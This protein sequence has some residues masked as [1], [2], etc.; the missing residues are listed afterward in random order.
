M[1]TGLKNGNDTAAL[2]LVQL[3]PRKAINHTLQLVFAAAGVA[4]KLPGLQVEEGLSVNVRG[5]NG[6]SAGNKGNI[7]IALYP[8]ALTNGG[9]RV[10]TPDTEIP[11]PVDHTAQIWGIAD[12]AGDGMIA[13]ISGTPIG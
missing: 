5:H 9:G 2:S 6:T 3:Q 12:N 8:E 1:V 7:R 11:F 13:S 10:I 4:Q